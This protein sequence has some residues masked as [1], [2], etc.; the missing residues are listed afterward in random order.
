MTST[1]TLDISGM[2][3]EHCV[4]AVTRELTQLPGVEQ[5]AVDLHPEATSIATVTVATD[6]QA[7]THHQYA[8]AID[9]AGYTLVD[10]H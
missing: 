10:A 6:A 8:E 1:T 2:T 4:Q 9:E 7:P 3:C 5:V